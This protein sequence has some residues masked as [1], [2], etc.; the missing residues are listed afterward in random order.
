MIGKTAQDMKSLQNMAA[1]LKVKIDTSQA[2]R[3]IA[4]LKQQARQAAAGGGVSPRDYEPRRRRRRGLG[5]GGGGGGGDDEDQ[6]FPRRGRG[7]GRG[8]IGAVAQ[9]LSSG[10]GLGIPLGGPPGLVALE[11]AAYAAAAALKKVAESAEQRDRAR[12]QAAVGATPEQRR[13]LEADMANRAKDRGPL[14]LS[15]TKRLELQTSLLGDVTGATAGDRARAAVNIADYIEKEVI[16]RQFALRPG[17]SFEEVQE[18]ARKLVQAMNLASTDIV[19]E[20]DKFDLQGRL[21]GRKGEMSAEGKRVAEAI[22]LAQAADPDLAPQLIKTTLANMKSSAL[23]MDTVAIAK[24]LMSAGSRGV[25]AANEM[26]RAQ[27]AFTGTVDVKKFNNKLRDLGL[28]LGTTSD[29]KGNVKA[30][31]GRAIDA[32]T[33]QRNPFEWLD[34]HFRPKME[35]DLTKQ[36]DKRAEAARKAGKSEEEVAKQREVTQA[37]R[38]EFISRFMAGMS[39]AAKQGVTDALLGNEQAN[40][41]LQQA[42]DALLKN[43]MPK[44]ME[45]SWVAQLQKVKTQLENQAAALGESASAA[46]DIPNKLKLLSQAI[47]DPKGDAAKT[48]AKGALDSI[49]TINKMP[50]MD[51]AARALQGAGATLT[52]AAYRLMGKEPPAKPGTPEAATDADVAEVKSLEQQSADIEKRKAAERDIIKKTRDDS[53]RAR[54]EQALI[55]YDRKQTELAQKA[56]AAR[57]RIRKRQ[58]DELAKAAAERD[59]SDQDP[60]VV[61]E[62]ANA[63]ARTEAEKRVMEQRQAAAKKDAAMYAREN[64]RLSKLTPAQIEAEKERHRKKK[65]TGATVE[66]GPPEP[67][68]KPEGPE[69]P[70][71]E[72]VPNIMEMIQ[73]A[74][75]LN[76]GAATK[77]TDAAPALQATAASFTTAFD[78]APEKIG[79]GGSVA[80]ENMQSGAGGVGSAIAAAFIAQASGLRIGVDVSGVT[81][82]KGADTGSQKASTQAA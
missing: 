40:Q 66:E 11:A 44:A 41:Q 65:G 76:D 3:Q 30:G 31:S 62:T 4:D 9:G 34:T 74:A 61:S 55:D 22:Q 25:R 20:T 78:S 54:A 16:P 82:A 19:N 75:E 39:G 63:K 60:I 7:F 53:L 29:A 47:A 52:E 8:A 67:P 56:E 77:M 45:A 33:L 28:L 58:Q 27:E 37:D 14:P 49:I 79:R 50:E 18:G 48:L 26:Y 1:N 36:A 2:K 15:D 17:A 24:T 6:L 13:I 69:K 71:P 12:L 68:L 10:F 72:P 5:G 38:V 43:N 23:R 70:I 59:I 42:Q 21:I 46:M 64:K 32:E 81:Q 51:L 80:I 35:A 73:K 57:A